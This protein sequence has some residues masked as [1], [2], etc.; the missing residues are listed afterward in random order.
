ML[1]KLAVSVVVA[2]GLLLPSIVQ[3]LTV[4]AACP[5]GSSAKG[6][7]LQGVGETG[8]DCSDKGFTGAIAEIVQIMSIIVGII[9][10]IMILIAGIKYAT[11]GGSSEKISGAKNTLIYAL[12]GVVVVAL[13]QF[14]VHFVLNVSSNAVK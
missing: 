11:S 4:Y 8:S 6:Q 7:V 1:K 5:A 9:A 10:I 14:L 13:A 3:P 12:V 2:L